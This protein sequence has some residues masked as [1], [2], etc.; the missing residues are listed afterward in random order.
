MGMPIINGQYR[1][2][3]AEQNSATTNPTTTSDYLLEL[4][5]EPISNNIFFF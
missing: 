3:A 1:L 4:V 2:I 5:E